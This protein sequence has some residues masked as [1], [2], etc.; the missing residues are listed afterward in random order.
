[1]NFF[2]RFRD[3]VLVAALLAIPFFFL[4]ANLKDPAKTNAVDRVVL[5]ISAPLQ[6]VSTQAARGVSAVIEEYVYLVDVGRENER[7]HYENARLSQ[8]NLR[9]QGEGQ[10]NRRLRDLL[11]MREQLGGEQLS[12]Q[13]IGKEVS[14]NFR[15]VRVRL[16]RGERD[17]VKPGMP[18][19]AP[20][21]LVGQVR[22]TWGRYSDVLLTVDRTSA[23]DVVL[24]RN[25]ARGML[26]GTGESDRYLC[27]IQ[28]LLRADEV[29]VG[30][31]VFTSGLGHRFPPNILVGRVTNVVRRDFGLYQEAE[32][33]PAANFSTLEAVSILTMG[34]REAGSQ[35]GAGVRG[36]LADPPPEI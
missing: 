5:Q 13:V 2:R 31:Q 36:D 22:R 1:V 19:V 33:T 12:A 29:R 32:V 20:E 18:V 8:E 34:A 14:A 17:R 24:E 26:R 15:V 23:I 7:L 35:D 11:Q 6:W 4:N 16:D 9:L 27:R 3:A 30:D 21:G 10:E 28:Y 25:G